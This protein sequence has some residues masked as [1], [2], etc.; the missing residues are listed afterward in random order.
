MPVSSK[1]MVHVSVFQHLASW[2][3]VLRA[4]LNGMGHLFL[5]YTCTQAHTH[6]NTHSPVVRPGQL[7]ILRTQLPGPLDLDWATRLKTKSYHQLLV[8]QLTDSRSWDYLAC[9]I[10]WDNSGNKS[11]SLFCFS[12]APFS[13]GQE[14]N[15]S[16]ACVFY[17]WIWQHN[18]DFRKGQN[19]GR[20]YY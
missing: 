1:P 19:P 5:S 14:S 12:G 16:G 18:F 3:Q 11:S 17:S 15:H 13:Y 7:Y 2:S 8:L 10:T 4:M 20:Y 6:T 9:I